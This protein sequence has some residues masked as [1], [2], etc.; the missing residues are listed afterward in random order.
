MLVEADARNMG[1]IKRESVDT[2]ISNELICDLSTQRQLGKAL[3]EFRRVLRP[4]GRMIHGE[5]MSSSHN[6]RGDF[7]VRHWPAWNPDELLV[8]F[9]RHGFNDFHVTYFDT[10]IAF[11]NQAAIHELQAWGAPARMIQR[12]RRT[13]TANGIRLPF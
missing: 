8:E 3:R 7:A 1:M 6:S 10:T 5:W 11:S 13:I 12:N 9:N 4:D 2:I